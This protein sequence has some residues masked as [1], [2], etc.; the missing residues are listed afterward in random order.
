MK[1][2]NIYDI[3]VGSG[4]K[5]TVYRKELDLIGLNKNV[6]EFGCSTGYVSKLLKQNG[7]RVTGIETDDKAANKARAFCEKIIV[8]DLE[9]IEFD[10]ELKGEKFDVALFGDVL[11]HLKDPRSILL[12]TKDILTKD[13]YLVISI[14]N[15]AHWSI[16]LELLCGNF[17][18]QTLG[19]LDDSHLRFF[20][21]KSITNLLEACGYFMESIDYIKQ[22][23]DWIKVNQVL[24]MN[25]IDCKKICL[26][27]AEPEAEAYQYLMKASIRSEHQYLEKLSAE[28]NEKNKQIQ[29]LHE[30][31]RSKENEISKLKTIIEE[32]NRILNDISASLGWKI[33]T[34]LKRSVDIIPLLKKE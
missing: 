33:L 6:L 2:S 13:G 26:M 8:G 24:K 28:I 14:P 1:D 16:R 20:T 10:K 12:K 25:E 29:E 9:V 7:C 18:Y 31:I 23:V 19:I 11:E 3:E 15:I 32:N 5:D 4:K 27:L 17:D 34:K 22:E 21:R 30:T